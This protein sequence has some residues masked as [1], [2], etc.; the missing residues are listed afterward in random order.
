MNPEP[1]EDLLVRRYAPRRQSTPE[2]LNFGEVSVGASIALPAGPGP[3]WNWRDVRS[4]KAR[5]F[6]KG[7]L[8]LCCVATTH[9]CPC[10]RRQWQHRPEGRPLVFAEFVAHDSRLQ[11]RGL[12]HAHAGA[13]N[14]LP[15]FG[16]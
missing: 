2:A 6:Y 11:I 9:F 15:L 12:N 3:L 14:L 7:L 5:A 16:Q 1:V 8:D 4:A 13:M 10:A